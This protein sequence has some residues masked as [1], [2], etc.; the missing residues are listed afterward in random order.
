[1]SELYIGLTF[2][3]SILLI[4]FLALSC[5]FILL[6]C[7]VCSSLVAVAF[8]SSNARILLRCRKLILNLF[9]KDNFV[10]CFSKYSLLI[11]ETD[12]LSYS[13]FVPLKPRSNLFLLLK[14][15]QISSLTLSFLLIFCSLCELAT[16][17]CSPIKFTYCY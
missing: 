5:S 17:L 10:T 7:F 8:S 9:I 12:F 3:L 13:I 11:S 14:T 2:S 4:N 15:S 16:S 6:L 1:M